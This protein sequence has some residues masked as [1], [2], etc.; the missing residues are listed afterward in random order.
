MNKIIEVLS[1][2]LKSLDKGH[3]AFIVTALFIALFFILSIIGILTHKYR[4]FADEFEGNYFP[5]NA[6]QYNQG[7]FVP[8]PSDQPFE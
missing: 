7:V 8:D 1:T 2:F 6:L 5:N 4:P 3:S